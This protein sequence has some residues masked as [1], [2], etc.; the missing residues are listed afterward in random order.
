[1]TNRNDPNQGGFL[2]KKV[3]PL[4]LKLH[5]N[6]TA[7]QLLGTS[8]KEILNSPAFGVNDAYI[9]GTSSGPT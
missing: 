7:D 5:W 6:V 9:K 8:L 3:C 4:G 2:R 1:M